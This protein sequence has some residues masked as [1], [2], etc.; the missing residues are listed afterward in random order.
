MMTQAMT[1]LFLL[2]LVYIL[3]EVA[4]SSARV[5]VH[6]YIWNFETLELMNCWLIIEYKFK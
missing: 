5:P 2:Y 1:S 3:T 4:S 6:S